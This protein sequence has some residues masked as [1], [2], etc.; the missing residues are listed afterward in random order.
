MV[1]HRHLHD[2]FMYTG[3]LSDV[4][5]SLEVGSFFKTTDILFAEFNHCEKE[6]Q[7]LLEQTLALPSY[8]QVLKAS[9]VFNLLDARQV[10]S[11]TERQQYILRIR[12]LARAVA[13]AYL[14]TREKMG[15]P[16]IKKSNQ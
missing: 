3:K 9:H 12:T 16:L 14:E 4:N 7:R 10:I 5:H 8:E 15:F 13:A 6:C 1:L 2:I 11:V